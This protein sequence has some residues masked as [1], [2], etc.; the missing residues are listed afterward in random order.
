MIK[1]EFSF[2][3]YSYNSAETDLLEVER[4]LAKLG[5]ACRAHHRSENTTMWTQGM[6]ILLVRDS[7]S[8]SEPKVTGIG[9]MSNQYTIERLEC[10]YDDTV[11][12]YVTHDC[13]GNRVLL[14]PES[15]DNL[16]DMLDGNYH[17]DNLEINSKETGM[18][19]I[20]G[21][22]LEGLNA[23]QMD[24]YQD[25]G[26]KFT[27]STERFN[28]LVSNNNRFIIKVD[29]N[30]GTGIKGIVIDCDDVFVT[31]SKLHVAGLMLKQFEPADYSS[32]GGSA[33]KINGYNCVAHGSSS[34]YTIENFCVN[35]V[36]GLDITIR[37]R[38]QY[39]DINDQLLELYY[40]EPTQ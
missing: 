34:S 21:A 24:F 11:E 28:T 37:S 22:I 1:A 5:C 10:E 32:F 3:E 13:G 23:R 7:A 36:S 17:V 6:C 26:F 4:G 40:E 33:H 20:T 31:T 29:K 19:C 35:P 30:S 25:L 15:G 39:L 2:L 14:F 18:E 38:K 16:G 8:V 27:K 12:M 9:L